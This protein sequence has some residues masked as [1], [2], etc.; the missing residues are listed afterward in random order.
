MH[1]DEKGAPHLGHSR[2]RAVANY[3]VMKPVYTPN[4]SGDV[5]AETVGNLHSDTPVLVPVA[6]ET[7][8]LARYY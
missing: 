1:G 8:W 4:S 3:V 5:F 6:F 7:E 2:G